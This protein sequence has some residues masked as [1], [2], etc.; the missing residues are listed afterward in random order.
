[1]FFV[2]LSVFFVDTFL[3]IQQS[4]QQKALKTASGPYQI[5]LLRY[6]VAFYLPELPAQ[7]TESVLLFLAKKFGG[8]SSFEIVGGW[9]GQ[10]ELV[11]EPIIQAKSFCSAVDLTKNLVPLI[12]LGHRLG[13]DNA[14]QAIAL[15]IGGAT[16]SIMLLIFIG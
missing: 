10:G 8:Y 1:M 13:Q 9:A 3:R 5:R 6:W 11:K 15:E 4:I 14:E 7:E 16:G 12:K 2:R